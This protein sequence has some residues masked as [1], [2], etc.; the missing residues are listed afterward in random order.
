M[1]KFYEQS[2]M[3]RLWED[4]KAAQAREEQ[5]RQA[6]E[7]GVTSQR[8]A[9]L[10]ALHAHVAASRPDGKPYGSPLP[11]HSYQ[12]PDADFLPEVEGPPMHDLKKN[13]AAHT[14]LGRILEARGR[15]YGTFDD[16]ARISQSLKDEFTAGRWHSL[17][18]DQ[19]EALHQIAAKIS[20]L[21]TG[22]PTY[23]DNWDDIAGY[24]KLVADRLRGDSK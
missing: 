7:Q 20:R 24:A 11:V 22:D 1:T 21:L 15:R 17:A 6:T 2:P 3:D 19:K 18:P 14:H 12:S 13:P 8:E 10:E 23:V 9:A 5:S 4:T 16:N